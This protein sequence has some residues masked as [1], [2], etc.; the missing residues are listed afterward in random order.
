MSQKIFLVGLPGAGKTTMGLDLG[1]D[2]HLQFIDLD[3]E[4]EKTTKM[5]VPELFE[6]KGE[7]HFR[8]MEK[9]CLESVIQELDS[10]VLAT[11]GGTPC[12]FSNMDLM[13]KHGTTVYISTPVEQIE[14]RLSMDNSRP[15]MKSNSLNDLLEK[16]KEWYEQAAYSIKK[17]DELRRL[18]SD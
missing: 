2:L 12:F 17:Y 18:F 15:L 9:K 3:L 1:V 8:Q 7:A 14:E 11:G 5:T 6:E 4:I 13:R 16:R 10:F